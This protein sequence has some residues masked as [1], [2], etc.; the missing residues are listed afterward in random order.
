MD[1]V[2]VRPLRPSEKKTLLR[3]KRQLTNAVNARHAR[4]LLLSR[5]GRSNREIAACLDCYAQWVRTIIHRFNA[6]G[7]DG[8]AWY[9]FFQTR[10]TPRAFGADVRQQ[11]AEVA[12]S[13][14]I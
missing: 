14:P 3:M 13:S 7:I 9:P 5:G 4:I 8:V 10:D 1:T 6:D 2:R 11:I 12:L